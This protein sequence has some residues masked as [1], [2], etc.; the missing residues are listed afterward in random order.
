MKIKFDFLIQA[1]FV[2]I[3]FPS[4]LWSMTNDEFTIW[5]NGYGNHSEVPTELKQMEDYFVNSNQ[6]GYSSNFW[7]VLNKKNIEQIVKY[8]YENFKQ[9]VT[10]NYFTWVVSLDNLYAA[11]LMKL[12]PQLK[13]T[14][15]SQEINKIHPF[16][17]KADSIKFNTITLYFLNYMLMIGAG[18]Y[19]EKLEEPLIGNPPFLTYNKKRI[20]QDILNSLLEYL[21]ISQHCPLD[22]ISTIIEIGAGSGR[23]AFCFMSLLPNVKY[24]IVD[25]PPALYVSQRYLSDV[26]P[27]KKVMTFRPFTKFEEVAKDFAQADIVFL[28]PDQLMSLPNDSADLFL[29]IDC[30]HEMKPEMI[31]H[32]FNEA[33]RLCSYIYFKCWQQTTMPYDNIYYSSESYPIHPSWKQLFK[34]A[35]VVPSDFFHAF[36]QLR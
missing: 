35:C 36:Y 7:N 4:I 3:L 10:Q 5:W 8:G 9:T 14:L 11:N 29:A 16:F 19:L 31:S 1:S 28:T 27:K 34:D 26:F 22:K 33:E 17:G 15:P 30:L 20:S 12:V 32:Y 2:I 23:S 18:P 24:V 21:P 13:V 6:I 25:I